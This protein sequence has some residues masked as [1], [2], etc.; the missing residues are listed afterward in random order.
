MDDI[1]TIDILFPEGSSP[2]HEYKF[3]NGGTYESTPNRALTIDDSSPTMVLPVAYFENRDPADYTDIEVM[4]H[5]RVDM[6]AETVTD[7]Y[8]AGSVHPL[9]WGWDAGWNDSLRLFDDG[10]HDDGAAGD[11]I[12]GAHIWFPPGSYRYVEYKYTTD[13]TDNEPLPPFENH[14]FE[15]GDAPHQTL[16]IDLFGSLD[17]VVEKALPKDFKVDVSPNPF[18]SAANIRVKIPKTGNVILEMFDIHGRLMANVYTGQLHQG[19]YDFVWEAGE[20]S[21]GLYLL[22]VRAEKME[23]VEKIFLVK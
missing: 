14:S 23:K 9:V 15:L 10:M 18:N 5:F 21:S 17:N 16:P 1:Y 19:V 12:Y 6:S 2:G 20:S 22:R 8:V 11:G 13:G 4:V 7:P 3:V